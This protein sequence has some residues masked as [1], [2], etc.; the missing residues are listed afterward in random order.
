MIAVDFHSKGGDPEIDTGDFLSGRTKQKI[1][2]PI[3]QDRPTGG[4]VDRTGRKALPPHIGLMLMKQE[5]KGVFDERLLDILGTMACAEE[6]QMP[7]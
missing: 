6:A 7:L 2:L 4:I 3:F 5:M 1:R